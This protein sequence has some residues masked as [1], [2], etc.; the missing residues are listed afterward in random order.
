[1]SKP[2][3]NKAITPILPMRRHGERPHQTLNPLLQ[4]RVDLACLIDGFTV[5]SFLRSTLRSAMFTVHETD[6]LGRA[7]L[8]ECLDPQASV[9]E[10][11]DF[12]SLSRQMATVH[13]V[14][15]PSFY[16]QGRAGSMCWRVIENAIGWPIDIVRQQNP[17]LFTGTAGINVL[18]H[19]AE[20]MEAIHLGTQ[21]Q[22]IMAPLD[23]SSI[24]MDPSGRIKLVQYPR[25]V[26]QIGGLAAHVGQ[27]AWLSPEQTQ[28]ETLTIQ[29]DIYG[30]GLIGWWIFS[31]RNPFERRHLSQSV[32]A[33]QAGINEV[34]TPEDMDSEVNLLLRSFLSLQPSARPATM[35]AVLHSLQQL[36]LHLP[37]PPDGWL[38]DL[39]S[40]LR[41][42][43]IINSPGEREQRIAQNVLGRFEQHGQR[44]DKHTHST[45]RWIIG[46]IHD[47]ADE[48]ST[49]L[50]RSTPPVEP[51]PPVAPP[52]P[53]QSAP[54]SFPLLPV[55]LILS[56][57]LC[58][59]ILVWLK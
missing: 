25:H 59:I 57:L 40:Q 41:T 56:G 11:E 6:P 51:P 8:M 28:N 2:E 54:A 18:I 29:S 30:I 26:S 17:A 33:I 39:R 44:V 22:A 31:G 42:V 52:V 23:I 47:E 3:E 35:K 37:P 14:G 46:H 12:I 4:E 15:V 19:I 53:V 9:A 16:Q 48:D 45:T 50:W 21:G 58:L 7:L 1:M 5:G 13:H 43:P 55:L 10:Q 24:V 34:P 20:A 27:R 38:A 36:C 32:D 49:Q